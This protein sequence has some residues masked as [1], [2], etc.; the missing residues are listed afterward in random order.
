M[1]EKKRINKQKEPHKDPF[2]II[3]VIIGIL[4]FILWLFIGRGVPGN[5]YYPGNPVFR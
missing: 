2:I 3:C 5:D 1:K 4:L